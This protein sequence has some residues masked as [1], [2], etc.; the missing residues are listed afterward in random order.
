ME[1]PADTGVERKQSQVSNRQKRLRHR[2]LLLLNILALALGSTA[3]P[4]L[5][6]FYFLHGGSKRWLSS[7]LETAGWPLLLLPLYLSYRK[8]PNRENHITPKLFLACCG[9]GILTGADD[10]LYAY[11][12]SFLPLSTASVL[13][14]SHLGFTA[15]FALL[16]VRQKFSPFSVNSVVLLSASSVLLAFHTSGDRPEGVTSRQ[17]VVGF[18]LTLGAAA[19]YGFV[20]PLIELTYKRA[21][22]PITYTLVME[23]QFVMSV[24][25][26]VFCTVGMLINGDFQALHREAEGFRLGKIDYSMAL[27]WAAV[28]WQLF[29]IGVFG[30]TSMASSLL[31][32]VIIALMIPGTEVLAVI[33]FHEKFS[34][35]KGMALVLALWGFASYLYGEYYYYLKLRPPDVP[36]QQ[37]KPEGAAHAHQSINDL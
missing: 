2:I 12:L 14:A 36:K 13:I 22:R 25:A 18:V 27:V 33:L 1:A 29:F 20:I 10:Y 35:E 19:L 23:M 3:G 9:I 31:S 26:T 37:S 24:T 21:K 6:R 8:Q 7:W 5:T 17:Y 34:A 4:L 11:G 16:L 15:G 32:G 28:A 30:V